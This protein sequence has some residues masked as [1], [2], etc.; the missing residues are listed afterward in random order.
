[1]E[2]RDKSSGQDIYRIGEYA[3][4]MGVTP[5]FLKHYEENGLLYSKQRGGGYRFYAFHQSPV[6]LECM[7]LRNYGVTVRE[8]RPL[9]DE[10]PA[11]EALEQL[12]L[13]TQAL[14]R[15][16][17]R[18]SA[19]VAEHERLKAWF[20]GRRD[21]ARAAEAAGRPRWGSDWEVRETQAWLYLPHSTGLS[22]L[23]DPRI[24]GILPRWID[25][26][27]VVKSSLSIEPPAEG[28]PAGTGSQELALSWGLIVKESDAHRYGI[29]LNEAVTRIPPGRAFLL[30]FLEPDRGDWE[31]VLEE[32]SRFALKQIKALG[33]RLRGSIQMVLL[34]HARM[35]SDDGSH[36]RC[37]FFLAPVH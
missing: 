13:K 5:D 30:H 32:R 8:M 9:I 36:E 3:R 7:R 20:A 16:I 37:G 15:R 21:A 12:D 28:A 29:P 31:D 2:G 11:E 33:L 17:E 27:P 23:D 1:M 35:N 34:M 18:D 6:I 25:W 10:L 4:S 26:M 14:R 19:V 22:F 24:R